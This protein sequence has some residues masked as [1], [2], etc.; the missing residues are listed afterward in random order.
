MLPGT[1]KFGVHFRFVF[2]NRDLCLKKS[3]RKITSLFEHPKV[4]T[5]CNISVQRQGAVKKLLGNGLNTPN[6]GLLNEIRSLY[7]SKYPMIPVSVKILIQPYA[8]NFG[9]PGPV[10]EDLTHIIMSDSTGRPSGC[11]GHVPGVRRLLL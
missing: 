9:H 6:C 10:L 11:P 7:T 1:L 5:I 8:S 3:A 2:K 4:D